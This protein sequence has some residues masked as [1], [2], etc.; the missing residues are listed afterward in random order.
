MSEAAVEHH[1]AGF[2]RW[3][4][5]QVDVALRQK[6]R[7]ELGALRAKIRELRATKAARVRAAIAACRA[8][9]ARQKAKAAAARQKLRAY[10]A[11]A[12]VEARGQCA[13]SRELERETGTR[14]IAET[15]AELERRRAD[16]RLRR[17]AEGARLRPRL[18][19]REARGES[20]DEV[21][22]NIPRELAPVWR[23][24]KSR[25]KA[26]ARRSRTEAFLEWVHD[27]S[28]TVERLLNESIEADVED[29][30]RQEQAMY[31][32][33]PRLRM[34]RSPW[35][36]KRD[37][38][39]VEIYKTGVPS[40]ISRVEVADPKL[41]GPG[42]FDWDEHRKAVPASV[43]RAA[44]RAAR[45]LR[46]NP[47]GGGGKRK[48]RNPYVVGGSFQGQL[49]PGAVRWNR[50]GI[51]NPSSLTHVRR[52]KFYVN[53]LK[54]AVAKGDRELA[55]KWRRKLLEERARPNPVRR[56]PPGNADRFA[57]RRSGWQ[58]LAELRPGAAVAAGRAINPKSRAWT[59]WASYA[60]LSEAQATVRRFVESGRRARIVHTSRGYE[61][62]F[63]PKPEKRNPRRNPRRRRNPAG[64][65][66][67]YALFA[68]LKRSRGD[69]PAPRPGFTHVTASVA[70]VHAA[71]AELR[72]A[73]RPKL[74]ARFAALAKKNPLVR[75]FSRASI[76]KNI[77]REQRRGVKRGQAV[78]IAL[79]VARK[80]AKKKTGRIPKYLQKKNPKKRP[81][82]AWWRATIYGPGGKVAHRQVAR[83]NPAQARAG[84]AQLAKRHGRVALDGP[85]ATKPAC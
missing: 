59:T 78:A 82:V 22:G 7:A 60:T 40:W 25:I 76:A 62:Q 42:K 75:G 9:R 63:V 51:G 65:R 47:G 74:A 32:Q 17:Q 70:Q 30:V 57:S 21:L 79:A 16:I 67:P 58:A 12:K 4:G 5:R 27:N 45:T 29:L 37:G 26:G 54:G 72:A 18:S 20:D 38:G 83:A 13:S 50:R 77:K 33:N 71:A 35:Y 48:R 15:K 19:T 56:A 85:F 52:V 53:M 34:A 41:Y 39:A 14:S 66:V 80:A 84:V 55:I 43:Q 28:A 68:A 2:Q 46:K 31:A 44:E 64:V 69:S 1:G 24:V 49:E 61:V 8:A 11:R 73:G 3:R 36:F 81:A 23:R 10:L 6:D